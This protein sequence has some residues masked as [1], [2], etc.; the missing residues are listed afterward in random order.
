MVKNGLVVNCYCNYKRCGGKQIDWR[1]HGV[2]A[3]KDAADRP[4]FP[5]PEE[6]ENNHSNE[7]MEQKEV[8]ESTDNLPPYHEVPIE[9]IVSHIDTLP[10]VNEPVFQTVPSRIL[11]YLTH[12]ALL[13]HD[14]C[15]APW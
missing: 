15:T 2:H 10:N 3:A 5:V 11:Q 9:D 6:D 13:M 1:T 7:C 4:L 14:W 8:P 12:N